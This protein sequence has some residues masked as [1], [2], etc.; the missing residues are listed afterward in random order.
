MMKAG[1]AAKPH[2]P[3]PSL[4]AAEREGAGPATDE[5][6]CNFRMFPLSAAERGLGGEVGP[7]VDLAQ[8]NPR[9]RS[10]GAILHLSIN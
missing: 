6:S 9:T 3:Q 1:P 10:A 7:A 8:K 5:F 2:P 4:S